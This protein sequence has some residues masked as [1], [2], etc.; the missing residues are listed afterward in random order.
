MEQTQE[1]RPHYETDRR[2]L[3]GLCMFSTATHGHFALAPKIKIGPEALADCHELRNIVEILGQGILQ[4]LGHA[5]VI[6]FLGITNNTNM[7]T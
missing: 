1:K 7:Q 2:L 3:L 5:C 6:A 4:I